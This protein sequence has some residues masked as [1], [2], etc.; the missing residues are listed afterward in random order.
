M[1][2]HLIHLRLSPRSG[3]VLVRL[4]PLMLH[5]EHLDMEVLNASFDAVVEDL[6]FI[7]RLH[8]PRIVLPPEGVEDV[9]HGHLISC[10]FRSGAKA[11]DRPERK[12][13]YSILEATVEDDGT[14]DYRSLPIFSHDGL[15]LVMV[16]LKNEGHYRRLAR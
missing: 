11:S 4:L 12:R 15:A 8:W 3:T 16:E 1:Q 5:F 6:I 7:L 13:D 10:S 14:C 2:R 9:F